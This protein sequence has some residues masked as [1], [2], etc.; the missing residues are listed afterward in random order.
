MT[1]SLRGLAMPFRAQPWVALRARLP[2]VRR[3]SRLQGVRRGRL[4]RAAR[5][6]S[7][8]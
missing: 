6:G 7:R 8:V 4:G 5:I 2:P 3:P 1:G